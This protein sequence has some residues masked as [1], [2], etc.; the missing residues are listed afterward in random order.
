M[1]KGPESGGK[2]LEHNNLCSN[3]NKIWN[4]DVEKQAKNPA[5]SRLFHWNKSVGTAHRNG[6]F[7]STPLPMGGTW[8]KEHEA[9]WSDEVWQ[10]EADRLFPNTPLLT[11][12][13]VD[14]VDASLEARRG[15]GS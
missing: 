2:L 11:M 15:T 14:E 1:K 10:R 4:R 13:E 6:V 8:N 12:R 7:R 3:W 5:F 9:G